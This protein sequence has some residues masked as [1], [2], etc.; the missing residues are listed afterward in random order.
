MISTSPFSRKAYQKQVAGGAGRVCFV[1]FGFRAG[2]SLKDFFPALLG[3]FTKQP[4]V[5][6]IGENTKR[7]GKT[8]K[9]TAHQYFFTIISFLT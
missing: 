7:G 3:V 6:P 8:S 9:N 4:R 2:S 1:P 5:E